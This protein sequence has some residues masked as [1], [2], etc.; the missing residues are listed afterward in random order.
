MILIHIFN[1]CSTLQTNFHNY[2]LQGQVN[3]ILRQAQI[4]TREDGCSNGGDFRKKIT[5][6]KANRT[7]HRVREATL[8]HLKEIGVTIGSLDESDDRWIRYILYSIIRQ[9]FIFLINDNFSPEND[10][11]YSPTEI[12]YGV[13][14]L[15]M[16]YLP[17]EH[18]AKV[19]NKPK[20]PKID[21]HHREIQDG[22]GVR[23]GFS[24]A[25]IQYMKKYNLLPHTGKSCIFIRSDI[26][27]VEGRRNNF[28]K[29]IFR[30]CD[31]LRS[32]MK[33]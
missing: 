22:M 23:P 2:F 20:Q 11:E 14:Q 28:F 25:S 13:K 3:N 6:S 29:L 18:L 17:D 1:I 32:R 30:Q 31:N 15:L 26:R 21:D 9:T 10:R 4:Q 24:F 16:K 8:K 33:R 5:S 19:T 27:R 12:S 7:L